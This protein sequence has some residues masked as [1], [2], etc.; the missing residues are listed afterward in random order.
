[1]RG[2]PECSLAW[3]LHPR[4]KTQ[5]ALMTTT[6]FGGGSAGFVFTKGDD[7]VKSRESLENLIPAKAGIQ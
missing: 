7:F 1:L 2:E 4:G 3:D 6:T 5:V